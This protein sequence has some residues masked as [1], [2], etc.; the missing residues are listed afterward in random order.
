MDNTTK[1]LIRGAA[2]IV[3]VAGATGTAVM[4][5]SFDLV[6]SFQEK[7]GF[8][9]TQ[10]IVQPVPPINGKCPPDK[11]VNVN[12]VGCFAYEDYKIYRRKYGSEI[13]R[14]AYNLS[15]YGGGYCPPEKRRYFKKIP[16]LLWR[17]A[18]TVSIGCFTPNEYQAYLLRD[19][20][21]RTGEGISRG[22]WGIQNQL[23]KPT[24]CYTTSYGITNCY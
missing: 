7:I 19:Q 9:K 24:T 11:R 1:L 8:R 21:K 14:R 5:D 23:S 6:N 20:I 16:A 18:R 13:D 2:A 12:N 4:I 15:V 17:K 22:L 10:K 3:I